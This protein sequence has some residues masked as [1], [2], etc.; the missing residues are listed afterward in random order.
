MTCCR[1]SSVVVVYRG[2]RFWLQNV[3]SVHGCLEIWTWYQYRWTTTVG[4]CTGTI[5]RSFLACEPPPDCLG[6]GWFSSSSVASVY[7]GSPSH[8]RWST[9]TCSSVPG[10]ILVGSLCTSGDT[11]SPLADSCAHP[12]TFWCTSHVSHNLLSILPLCLFYMFAGLPIGK[13]R[14]LPLLLYSLLGPRDLKLYEL[15][16]IA[17]IFSDSVSFEVDGSW[18]PPCIFFVFCSPFFSILI[19]I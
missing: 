5:N 14:Y 15:C 13:P 10:G 19:Q 9:S 18:C 16:C 1:V 17:A 8:P 2:H 4:T 3:W 12:R 7:H 11:L 6:P